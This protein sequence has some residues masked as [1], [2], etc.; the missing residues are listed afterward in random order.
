MSKDDT[1]VKDEA[2]DEAATNSA[3]VENEDKSLDEAF[4]AV[5]DVSLDPSAVTEGESE[6]EKASDSQSDAPAEETAADSPTET[7]EVT[8]Q[9]DWDS[10]KGSSKERFQQMA[11]E[12]REAQ[13][14][15]AELEAQQAQIAN[16]QQLLNEINPET[17][18]YYTPQEIDRINWLNSQQGAQER[19]S[20]ELYSLQVEQNQRAINDDIMSAVAENPLVNPQSKDYNPEIGQEFGEMLNDSLIY[21]LADGQQATRAVL[22]ANGINPDTQATLVGSNV[23]ARKLAKF[24]A[25]SY[26][27]AKAQGEAIGQANAQRATEKMMANADAPSGVP[28]TSGKNELSDLFDRIKDVP[29]A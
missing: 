23:S 10:L 18:D 1:A 2:L 14:R 11:N 19:N 13:R 20:Q 3:D 26:A 12:R 5:K 9:D 4:E 17:G 16:G 7:K 15:I 27:G 21:Q 6:P 8:G 24:A 28:G 22:L 25:K 29:L